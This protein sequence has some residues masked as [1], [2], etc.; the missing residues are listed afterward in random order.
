MPTPIESVLLQ[1]ANFIVPATILVILALGLNIQWGHTGLFNAGVAAFAGVGAYLFGMLATG[2]FARPGLS[3]YH[4]GPG[5]PFDMIVA[6]VLA[7]AFAGLLGTLIAIPTLRLRADYLAIATLALAE[8]V[9]LILKNERMVTGGDQSLAFIP[10]PFEASV[11]VGPYS[12]GLFIGIVVGVAFAL[13]FLLD[14]LTRA[15]YGRNLHA[16][17]EDEEAALALGKDSFKLKLSAFAIGS[18]IMGLAG[19]MTAS[20]NK[21][22][23]PDNF[24]PIFTFTAYVVVILGGS[25]NNRGVILGGYVFYLFSW[26]TQQAKGYMPT[27][28]SIRLDFIN[29]II[30]GLLLILLILFRPEGIMKEPKYLP[31]EKR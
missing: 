23:V 21:V 29:Q 10:R 31:P 12:D 27:A 1:L 24:V 19:I 28:W 3:W 7:M 5:Q 25:G 30:I 2:Q 11:P 4:W 18:A 9:R 13:L 17:R 16:V 8:I 14:Y 20:F 15:P 6:A 22:I 26:T